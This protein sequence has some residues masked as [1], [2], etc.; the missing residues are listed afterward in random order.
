MA[1]TRENTTGYTDDQ[2]DRLNLEWVAIIAA[3]S[4]EPD[5]EE[6]YAREKQ[7]HDGVARRAVEAC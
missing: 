6:Y 3:E 4:L 7:F 2:L 1:F 5:S